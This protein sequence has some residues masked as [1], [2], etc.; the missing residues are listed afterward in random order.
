MGLAGNSALTIAGIIMAAFLVWTL[1]DCISKAGQVIVVRSLIN[2]LLGAIYITMRLS[3]HKTGA[4][5]FSVTILAVVL[6]CMGTAE[7][8]AVLIQRNRLGIVRGSSGETEE[9]LME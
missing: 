1:F 8:A 7:L 3:V 4:V 5:I 2:V 9:P 6:S